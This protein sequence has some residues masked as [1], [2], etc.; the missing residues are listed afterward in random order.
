MRM[1]RDYLD[2]YE[3]LSTEEALS[4]IEL[5]L[6]EK[7]GIP[8]FYGGVTLTNVGFLIDRIEQSK[9]E[10]EAQERYNSLRTIIR[11]AAQFEKP[12]PQQALYT[13]L[14][15]TALPKSLQSERNCLQALS[16]MRIELRQWIKAKQLIG[17]AL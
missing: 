9:G 2:I 11:V 14:T 7:A 1:C 17:A 8:D 5:V 6:R 13:I 3:P 4:A 12:L 16:I 10:G 15:K